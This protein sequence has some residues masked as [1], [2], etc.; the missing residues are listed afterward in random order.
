MVYNR[1]NANGQPASWIKVFQLHESNFKLW[2]GDAIKSD[3][4]LRQH[5]QYHLDPIVEGTATEDI[6]YELLLKSGIPPT[7]TIRQARRVVP[8]AA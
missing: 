1:G 4:D 2:R 8:G 5:L 3:Q 6:L 7:A